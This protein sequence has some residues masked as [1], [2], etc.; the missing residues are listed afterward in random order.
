MLA[1]SN[2]MATS[3]LD[4]IMFEAPGTIPEESPANEEETWDDEDETL[5][6]RDDSGP[7]DNGDDEEEPE[8]PRK[9]GH[10]IPPPS[11]EQAERAF[12]DLGNILKPRCKKGSGF[13]DPGLDRIV[14]ERLSGMKLLCYNYVEMQKVKP[15]S[16]QWGAASLRTANSLGSN[17]YMA[18]ALRDW[19][20]VFIAD[21]E[22]IP[23]HH[24]NRCT[25]RSHID[26]DDFAQELHLH[27]QSIGE[28]CTTEDIIRYVALPEILAKL[29]RKATISHATAHCW[30]QKMGYQW[31]VR[32]HGQYADGHERPD[33]VNYHQNV[34]LPAIQ[35]LEAKTQ[36][37]GRDGA[38]DGTSDEPCTVLWFH[39]ESMFYAHNCQK[40]RWVYKSE[41]AT[42]YAKGEGHSLMIADFVS[43]DYGWLRSPDGK[44]VLVSFSELGKVVM[45]TLTMKISAHRLR[46]QW[47][48]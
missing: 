37:W 12:H 7:I 16:S 36:K 47:R 35:E 13:E 41:K 17:I 1:E 38:E 40:K 29:N 10:F 26:D 33:V 42:P 6:G 20:H 31:T 34:F 45:D 32:P 44:E 3:I 25:G 24:Q 15:T 18:R 30:M 28:Y 46:T 4:G 11:V 5:H 22:F 9:R 27:L 14:M 21:P 39:D 23:E 19:T 43:A 2:V 8:K 48:S